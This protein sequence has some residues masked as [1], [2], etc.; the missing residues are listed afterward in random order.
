MWLSPLSALGNG[1]QSQETETP[2]D[3]QPAEQVYILVSGFW[4]M[5]LSES[6]PLEVSSAHNI[7][8]WQDPC[9][10]RSPR[11]ISGKSS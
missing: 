8:S 2:G 9:L 5:K 11:S 4:F 6:Q 10:K 3:G 7:D 1:A